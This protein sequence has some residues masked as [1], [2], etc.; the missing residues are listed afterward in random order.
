MLAYLN[1]I[2]MRRIKFT[3]LR[4]GAL[5]LAGSA[6]SNERL[7]QDPAEFDAAYLPQ[8]VEVSIP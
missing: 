1:F 5:L 6:Y 7:F 3:T 8:M 4:C 2:D